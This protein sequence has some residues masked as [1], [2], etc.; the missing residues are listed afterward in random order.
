MPGNR[1]IKMPGIVCQKYCQLEWGSLA[2]SNFA[3]NCVGT[4]AQ[5]VLRRAAVKTLEQTACSALGVALFSATMREGIFFQYRSMPVRLVSAWVMM[6]KASGGR[7]SHVQ[8]ALP[9]G[10]HTHT[11]T[12]AKLATASWNGSNTRERLAS[13]T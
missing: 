9:Q 13:C 3:Q 2:G 1:S 8:A 4:V 5:I 7:Q 11:H 12:R 10:L 6:P